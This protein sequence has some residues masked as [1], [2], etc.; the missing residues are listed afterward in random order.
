MPS[1]AAAPSAKRR[2]TRRVNGANSN[3]CRNLTPRRGHRQGRVGNPITS[4]KIGSLVIIIIIS[5]GTGPFLSL[6]QERQQAAAMAFRKPKLIR[7]FLNETR[8]CQGNR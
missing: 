2:R 3:Y 7:A 5:L 4:C 1:A 8:N 6:Y